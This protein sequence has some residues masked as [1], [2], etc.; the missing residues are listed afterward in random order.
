M[1]SSKKIHMNTIQRILCIPIEE[2]RSQNYESNIKKYGEHANTCFICGKR[3]KNM[4]K[5]KM[6][7]YL[8]TGNIVSYAGD[9]IEDSQGFFPVGS[10][11]AKKID[12][13]LVIQFAF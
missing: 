11:C 4:E 1:K 6:V 5:S 3:I 10:N 2:V 9:D 13:Y 7:H 12:L 8:T